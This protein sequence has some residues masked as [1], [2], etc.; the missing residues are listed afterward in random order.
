MQDIDESLGCLRRLH[1]EVTL[2]KQRQQIDAESV[3]HFAL[4]QNRVCFF[5][6]SLR[7]NGRPAP[8]SLNVI[9]EP[10]CG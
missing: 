9:M 10:K 5:L 7:L 8:L 1:I 2:I 6:L 3:H 4:P